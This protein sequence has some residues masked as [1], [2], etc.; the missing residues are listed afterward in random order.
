MFDQEL[1][2][3]RNICI[4]VRDMPADEKNPFNIRNVVENIGYTYMQE[5][6]DGKVQVVVLPN[7]TAVAFGRGVGYN[8]I[9]Y[10]PPAKISEISATK[11]RQQLNEE[12]KTL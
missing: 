10:I 5:I 12:G 3:G 11:I 6:E 1:S 4:A 2:A 8:I 7:I 9:E